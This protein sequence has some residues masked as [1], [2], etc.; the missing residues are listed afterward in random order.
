MKRRVFHPLELGSVGSSG[1][2][3]SELIVLVAAATKPLEHSLRK[4]V[5]ARRRECVTGEVGKL[6]LTARAFEKRGCIPERCVFSTWG[7]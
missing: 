7:P 2:V 6:D 1:R 3:E 4:F 5:E